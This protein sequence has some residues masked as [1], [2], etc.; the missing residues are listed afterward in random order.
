MEAE[1]FE[2][3]EVA[4]V[5]NRH[6]V[7]IKVDR[8]ERPDIDERYMSVA[9]MMT[10]SGGWPL[11]IVM[12]PD[13]RPFFAATYLPVEPRMGMPGIIQLLEKLAEIWRMERGKVEASCAA[14]MA[15]L[16]R[17]A[18]PDSGAT[19][20]VEI[21]RKALEQLA[22]MY[23]P[24]WGGFGRA[25]KFPVPQNLIFLLRLWKRTGLPDLLARTEKTLRMIRR[26][27]IY[28]QLGFGIHRYATDRQWLIPHFEKMLYDQALVATAYLETFQATGDHFYRRTAEEI[29][30]YVLREMTSPEGGF[31]AGQDADTEG[32]EGRYY[33]WTEAEIRGI[34][35]EQAALFCRLFGVTDAGNFEGKNILYLPLEPEKF[36]TL[37]GISLELLQADL[38]RWQ[39]LLLASRD[40]RIR[41]FRDEKTITAWNGLIIAAFAKGFA[42]TGD[43]RYLSAAEGGAGFIRERLQ[44]PTGRLLRSFHRGMGN[45]PAFLE[46][47]AFF[48]HGLIGLY[49]AT[50]DRAWLSEALRLNADMLRLFGDAEG[51]LFDTGSDAEVVL[52]RNKSAA[53]VATPSGNSMAAMNL[54]RLGRITEDDALT[55]EG[56]RILRAFMGNVAR[57]PA[58]YLYFLSALDYFTAPGVEITLAGRHDDPETIAMLRIVGRRYIPN[59]VLRYS[60]DGEVPK[61]VGGKSTAWLC[62]AGA[63]RPPVT[64]A[65]ALA[66]VLDEVLQ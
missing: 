41:P 36:A 46:D 42:V 11:N 28:D 60:G 43:T 50:L 6:F 9:Q 66:R 26:G 49:E 61:T 34:L 32:E 3:S 47:Y 4:E 8:E 59:L 39:E 38:E 12:T 48:V 5:I 31:Y 53:D 45:V 10:G 55:G 16:Q 65:L 2:N 52:A 56:E 25:P 24:E 19:A 63:C 21:F 54:L 27:G 35:G 15:E 18:H 62:A 64:D 58:G 23:D 13:K 7:A 57:Q 51:G 30:A 29:L 37:E 1:S 17:V 22:D 33:V 40:K 14:V 20:G 44:T